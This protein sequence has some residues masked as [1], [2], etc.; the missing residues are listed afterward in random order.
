M[1][2]TLIGWNTFLFNFPTNLLHWLFGYKYWVI[3]VEVPLALSGEIKD[4][5]SREHF[6]TA[7]NVI[8]ILINFVFCVWVSIKR[9][10]LSV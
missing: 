6:Y 3:S 1:L 4:R 5:R 7:L 10:D 8:M 9:Y 2:A